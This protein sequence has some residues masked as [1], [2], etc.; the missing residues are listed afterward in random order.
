MEAILA[1]QRTVLDRRALARVARSQELDEPVT[2]RPQ[3]EALSPSFAALDGGGMTLNNSPVR[4]PWS[5]EEDIVEVTVPDVR[6][7]SARAAVRRMHE[8][9][10]RVR[11]DGSGLV[12][13]LVP[14]AGSTVILGDTVHLI[15]MSP[16]RDE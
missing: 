3:G 9:G 11:S 15:S 8:L 1:S 4:V 13:H 6:G 5:P 10:F 12:T 7:L 2:S 14:D 16:V